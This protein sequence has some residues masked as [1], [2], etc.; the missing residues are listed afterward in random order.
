MQFSGII[1]AWKG[2]SN[3]T[4]TPSC[5]GPNSAWTL[6]SAF[7]S[8]LVYFRQED[9]LLYS[10]LA[11]SSLVFPLKQWYFLLKQSHK[12]C[13]SLS[14]SLHIHTYGISGYISV[15]QL[16]LETRPGLNWHLRTPSRGTDCFYYYYFI[17]PG[18][19]EKKPQQIQW[20]YKL[21]FTSLWYCSWN[22]MAEAKD[23][24][25]GTYFRQ[26]MVIR[27]CIL[28]VNREM[29]LFFNL[30]YSTGS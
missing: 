2:R 18:L 1:R 29:L 6:T 8:N 5:A 7:S 14:L 15:P 11:W 26:K 25:E 20:L 23:C 4:K 22:L 9:A 21:L 16:I 24:A 3:S 12:N 10:F 28:K 13:S 27:D 19:K 30:F 17:M